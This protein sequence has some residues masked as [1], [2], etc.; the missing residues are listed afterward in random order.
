MKLTPDLLRVAGSIAGQL[1]ELSSQALHGGGHVDC[2]INSK[3]VKIDSV[4][5]TI[6]DRN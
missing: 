6:A 5:K 1:E 4:A 3:W 2:C